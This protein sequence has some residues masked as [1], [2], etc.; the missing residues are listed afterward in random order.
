MSASVSVSFGQLEITQIVSNVF[1]T[2]LSLEVNAITHDLPHHVDGLT[3]TVQILGESKG[4]L[5]L[6]CSVEQALA[7]TSRMLGEDV[8]GL[9]DDVL[10]VLGELANVVGGNLKSLFS[11]GGTLSLPSVAEGR[12]YTVHLCRS[13]QMT[14]VA[15]A[16]EVG[17]FHVSLIRILDNEFGP[18]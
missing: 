2:M 4:A 16:S 8:S 17:V 7:F 5:L 6:H 9:T 15:F 18:N 10:D 14:T 1:E 11:A 12:D 13:N 3:A